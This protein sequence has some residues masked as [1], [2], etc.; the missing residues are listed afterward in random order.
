MTSTV[1]RVAVVVETSREYGRGVLRGI[2]R[3]EHEHGPWSIYFQPGG[4]GEPPPAWF[5]DWRGDGVL[6]R[7]DTPQLVEAVLAKRVP[8]VDLRLAFP[9]YQIPFVGVDNRLIVDLAFRDL[10]ERGFSNFAFLGL[11]RR[12]KIWWAE[13]RGEYFMQLAEQ[14]GGTCH[15]FQPRPTRDSHAI[16]EYDREK[17]VTWVKGLPRPVAIM[18][19][20]D[21]CSLQVAEVCRVVGFR[22]PDD[23]AILGVD[24]DEFLCNLSQPSMSS[25]D[26]G[27]ERSGYQ[28]AALLDEMMSGAKVKQTEVF[29]PP[30]GVVARRSTDVIAIDDLELA[31]L[32]RYIREHAC[33]GIRVEDAMRRSNLCVSTLQRRFKALLGRTPKEE[34]LRVQFERA[35]QLLMS[36]DLAINEVADRCGFREAKGLIAMFHAQIG[37]P[38]GAYRREMRLGRGVLLQSPRARSL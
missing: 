1:K 31:G 12:P 23:V 32:I 10:L 6:V 25:V 22:V 20:S 17:L 18:G 34:L 29:L 33:D 9:E 8:V 11:S 16:S 36:T 3:Y 37:M 2:I 7:A 26:L 5:R 15:V 21:D 13:Q 28:A 35:K 24:N 27:P 19:C 14:A 4:L 30:I 38:P